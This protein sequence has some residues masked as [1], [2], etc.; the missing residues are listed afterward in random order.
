[1]VVLQP[2]SKDEILFGIYAHCGLTLASFGAV[3]NS[4]QNYF[5][6]PKKHYI[7]EDLGLQTFTHLHYSKLRQDQVVLWELKSTYAV[8]KSNCNTS[9]KWNCRVFH[10]GDTYSYLIVVSVVLEKCDLKKFFPQL[11]LLLLFFFS[12]LLESFVKQNFLFL[13]CKSRATTQWFKCGGKL[14]KCTLFQ[15]W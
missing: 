4:P 14:Y 15:E 6:W 1:M 11:F 8:L 2:F 3:F 9:M 5:W 12:S 7:F 10:H 13:D